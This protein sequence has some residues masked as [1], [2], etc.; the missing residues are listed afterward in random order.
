M[1][2]KPLIEVKQLHKSFPHPTTPLLAVNDVSFVIYEK[3]TLGLVGESGCGKSTLG[4]LLLQIEKPTSGDVVFEGYNLCKLQA[5]EMKKWR[6]NLQMIFQD[7]YACLNPRMTIAEIIAEPIDIHE[8]ST[9]KE[10]EKTIDRLLSLVGL[11]T[12]YKMRFPH[13]LSGGQK[14]RVGIA[15]ALALSPKFLV[16]DEPISALDVSVQA[17]IINLLKDLQNTAGLTYLFISHNLGL[18]RYICSRVA[19]MYLGHLVELG[20]TD[21]LYT[22]PLHP[23]TQALLSAIP[24]ADPEKERARDKTILKGEIPK[25][26]QTPIGCCFASRC[27]KAT[28]ACH[29]I[30]PEWKQIKDDH[31]VACHHISS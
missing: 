11:D 17:Q 16:C 5:K 31:F 1:S 27:P 20:R 24:I 2:K 4:K 30:K 12:S 13:E 29:T 9:G 7:P 8:L 25:A 15:R 14:Q 19:V 26:R 10:R 3:E 22:S 23:Y 28:S 6:R 18:V 21:D